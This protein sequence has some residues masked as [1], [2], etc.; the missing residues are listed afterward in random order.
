LAWNL[1]NELFKRHVSKLACVLGY[2]VGLCVSIT[3]ASVDGR[4]FLVLLFP[5]AL[6]LLNKLRN[7]W[8]LGE[9]IENY[10]ESCENKMRTFGNTKIQNA[11]PPPPYPLLSAG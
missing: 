10:H 6:L 9:L 8:E 5:L 11:I 2:V 4:R 7:T 3:I 1:E